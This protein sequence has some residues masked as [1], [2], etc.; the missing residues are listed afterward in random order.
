MIPAFDDACIVANVTLLE[1]HGILTLLFFKFRPLCLNVLF[2]VW[3]EQFFV[4]I[5]IIKV[6][7]IVVV[8]LVIFVLSVAALGDVDALETG[9]E[10]VLTVNEGSNVD[11]TSQISRITYLLLFQ[12]GPASLLLIHVTRSGSRGRASNRHVGLFAR[13][14]A[15]VRVTVHAMA[16]FH[17]AQTVAAPGLQLR[18]RSFTRIFLRDIVEGA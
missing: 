6:L 12:D 16:R 9:G 14:L 17:S 2:V 8:F 5:F 4:V 15:A 10:L 3:I 1:Q 18:P 7:L 11:S 13:R